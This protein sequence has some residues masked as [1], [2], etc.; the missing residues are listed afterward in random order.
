LREFFHEKRAKAK[1]ADNN[2]GAK[3]EAWIQAVERL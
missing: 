3:R 2:W 1:P